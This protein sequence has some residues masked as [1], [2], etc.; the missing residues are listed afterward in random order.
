MDRTGWLDIWLIVGRTD[1]MP[2]RRKD[3]YFD[4]LCGLTDSPWTDGRTGKV[5]ECLTHGRTDCTW[6]TDIPSGWLDDQLASKL[7]KSDCLAI[8]WLFEKLLISYHTDRQQNSLMSSYHLCW[9]LVLQCK[10][11]IHPQVSCN[12]NNTTLFVKYKISNTKLLGTLF[13]YKYVYERMQYLRSRTYD[14][15]LACH[16]KIFWD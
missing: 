15:R 12:I 6:L 10:I 5:I 3:K 16:L 4:W 1:Y 8:R 7:I 14:K 13:W 2:D 9:I 11:P